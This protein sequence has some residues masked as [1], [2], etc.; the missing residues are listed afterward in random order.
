MGLVC[1]PVGSKALSED[2]AN[3]GPEGSPTG[4]RN[5]FWAELAGVLEA[6]AD[7]G[8][9]PGGLV[10]RLSAEGS[11]REPLRRKGRG[12]ERGL[13]VEDEPGKTGGEGVAPRAESP[14]HSFAGKP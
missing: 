14:S 7:I 12:V 3:A 1:A 2:A 5:A 4:A 9:E 11:R 6:P 13:D 10:R 8:V